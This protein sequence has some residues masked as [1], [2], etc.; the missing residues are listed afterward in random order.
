MAIMLCF[1]AIGH[2]LFIDGMT[3]IIPHFIP[4]KKALVVSSG[5]LEIAFAIALLIPSFQPYAGQIQI[6]VT[7]DALG[8][9]DYAFFK[10]LDIS[11][12]HVFI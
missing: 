9:S 1:T 6:Y 12:R 8:E 7:R 4:F 3:A 5:V 10:T 2:F 11:T